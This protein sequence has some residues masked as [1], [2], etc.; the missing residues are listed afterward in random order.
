M[1]NTAK[2]VKVYLPFLLIAGLSCW[3]SGCSGKPSSEKIVLRINNYTI[4]TGEFNELF[5][6]MRATEDTPENRQLFMENLI[7]RK[8]LLQEA[9][10]RGLDRE[11]EF[12][13]SIERFWEQSLL[14]IIIEEKVKEIEGNISFTE[15]EIQQRY[16][17]WVKIN[18]DDVRPL[19]DMGELIKWE[20][21]KTKQNK[22][23]ELW[24]E[25][26]KKDTRVKIN[27]KALGV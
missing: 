1:Y 13:K 6:E 16:M 4:T 23:L 9:Q 25:G 12:L 20:L 24:I 15:E 8:L 22:I 2:L 18:P 26:L 3:S 10:R 7:N 17:E 21:L 11:K 5:N 27:K 19:E 14:K